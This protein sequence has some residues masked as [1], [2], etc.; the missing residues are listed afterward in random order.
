MTGILLFICLIVH[1]AHFLFWYL[2]TLYNIYVQLIRGIQTTLI[3]SN[4]IFYIYYILIKSYFGTVHILYHTYSLLYSVINQMWHYK[5][6]CFNTVVWTHKL[7][8][9]TSATQML[10]YCMKYVWVFS[11]LSQTSPLFK[12]TQTSPMY[13]Q[14]LTTLLEEL[15]FKNEDLESLTRIF[16]MNWQLEWSVRFKLL[17]VS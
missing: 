1:S 10:L 2:S 11:R 16:R 9:L 6:L 15:H 7:C 5:L 4:Q 13:T 14:F 17:C 12:N 8:F 3:F